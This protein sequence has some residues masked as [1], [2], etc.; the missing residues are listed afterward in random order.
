MKPAE[1]ASGRAPHI[2]RSLTVPCTASEPMSPP[3]K[4]QRADDEGVG[5]EGAGRAAALHLERLA[6][7]VQ[8][9][10]SA[11]LREGRHEHALDQHLRQPAAAAVRQRDGRVVADRDGALQSSV[12][13]ISVA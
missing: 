11:G 12:A 2:A 7:V 6:P 4:K 1:S 5:G 10:S 13:S 9:C 8:S 3:G